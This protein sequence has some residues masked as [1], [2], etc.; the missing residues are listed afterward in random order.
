MENDINTLKLWATALRPWIDIF[1]IWVL[2]WITLRL[3]R[4]SLQTLKNHIVGRVDREREGRR[5]ETLMNVFRYTANVAVAAVAVM[6]T[7]GTIGISVA[8]LLATAG[9]A[10]IAIGFGAQSLVKDFFTGLFLL[11]EN[12]VS[13]GDM[14]EAAGKSGQVERVTLRHIRVRDYDGSVHFIPN[15]MITTVTN[16]SRD[17]AYAVID[18][19]V[20][21]Q[22]D[23]NHV[24]DT[25]RE[26]GQQLRRD[27]ALGPSILDDI[28]I[29]GVEQVGDAT[30]TL[31]CRIKVRPGRQ[32]RI[33]RE[34]LRAM[35]Q[36]MDEVR[37][38]EAAS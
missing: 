26:I 37:E 28:D 35:K 14:I 38:V 21:R 12:Q 30:V 24:F 33:R 10:G 8:P 2:A 29:G 32:W 31:R 36:V 9:V 4:H 1:V 25:M 19:N 20:R 5:I 18:L 3:I 13:E 23:L 17:F 16:R 15:G 11:I 34:F 6:L 22:D 27:P 7:L